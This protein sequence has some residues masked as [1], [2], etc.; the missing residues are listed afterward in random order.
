LQT[1]CG[2][3]ANG[4]TI[5]SGSIS[6]TIPSSNIGLNQSCVYMIKAKVITNESGQKVNVASVNNVNDSAKITNNT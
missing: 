5:T 2:Y 6:G 1:I 3:P 4:R